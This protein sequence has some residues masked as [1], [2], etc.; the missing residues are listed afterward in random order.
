MQCWALG[1]G[2]PGHGCRKIGGGKEAFTWPWVPASSESQRWA[3]RP[4]QSER[5][6]APTHSFPCCGDRAEALGVLSLL[7]AGEKGLSTAGQ[8]DLQIYSLATA[9]H[10]TTS[11]GLHLSASLT[12][13]RQVL[14]ATK[15]GSLQLIS[16]F[17][18]SSLRVARLPLALACWWQSLAGLPG[19]ASSQPLTQLVP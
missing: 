18:V 1:N 17:I 7:R 19:K 6:L 11:P 4:G 15:V 2:G 5:I 9:G 16:R 13:T 3:C 8:R 14:Q 10:I 12:R